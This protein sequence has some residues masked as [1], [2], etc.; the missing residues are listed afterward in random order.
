M[1]VF[2]AWLV[3]VADLLVSIRQSVSRPCDRTLHL[4]PDESGLVFTP[5]AISSN[6]TRPTNEYEWSHY[7]RCLEQ[8]ARPISANP[9]PCLAVKNTLHDSQ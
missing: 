4:D 6:V 2:R 1:I 9:S 5:S 7:L 3:I 8:C